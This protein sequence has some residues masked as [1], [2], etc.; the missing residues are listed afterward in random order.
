MIIDILVNSKFSFIAICIA[1]AI[2]WRCRLIV[3]VMRKMQAEFILA[4]LL[5][6]SE[7]CASANAGDG[8]KVADCGASGIK[9]YRDCL[10]AAILGGNKKF[11]RTCFD[12]L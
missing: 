2:Y 6:E 9:L 12:T 8:N 7:D 11:S 4:D 10:D 5:D 1:T 3:Y